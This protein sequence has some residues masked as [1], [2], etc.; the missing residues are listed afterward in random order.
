MKYRS[1]EENARGRRVPRRRPCG[2]GKSQVEGPLA[3]IQIDRFKL[4]YIALLAY[5][6]SSIFL[7]AQP[8]LDS[9]NYGPIPG[10][11][12]IAHLGGQQILPAMGNGVNWDYVDAIFAVDGTSITYEIPGSNAPANSTVAEVSDSDIYTYF[13]RL[14]A[15]GYNST[16]RWYSY[17]VNASC[18]VP[19]T[20][21][22]FPFTY[23][24][25]SSTTFS[26]PG[27][28]VQLPF[29]EDG[30]VQCTGVG[31]GTLNLPYGSV[32]SVLL[33][34]RMEYLDHWTSDP[35]SPIQF[36]FGYSLEEFIF[37]KP[38]T[39]VPLLRIDL[40]YDGQD[41]LYSSILM[42][43]YTVGIRRPDPQIIGLGLHPNPSSGRFIVDFN[44]SRT[45]DSFYSVYDATGR[46]LFQRPLSKSMGA[47]EINL[48]GYGKGMYL[49]RFSDRDGICAERVVVE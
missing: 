8:V 45:V 21:V 19:V 11:S 2:S 18:N 49:I 5:L 24:S 37:L 17:S 40:K 46:L 36:D 33:M 16:G 48:S 15:T 10:V 3:I 43:D 39:R 12:Y 32:D 28:E 23:G 41:T 13:Y 30:F 6:G 22:Q 27:V 44:G 4:P 47:V 29:G 35:H 20:Q 26:C 14:D 1:S 38:G 42:E 25:S 31:F 9:S 7:Q 34:H